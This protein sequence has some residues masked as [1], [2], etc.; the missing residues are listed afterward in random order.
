M[1]LI[2]PASS[3]SEWHKTTNQ[4]TWNY[5]Q[6]NIICKRIDQ[7]K[8]LKGLNTFRHLPFDQ[9]HQDFQGLPMKDKK[10]S[11]YWGAQ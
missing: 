9:T 1:T 5:H 2:T 7:V 10:S 8:M 11:A 3:G 4:M 6:D